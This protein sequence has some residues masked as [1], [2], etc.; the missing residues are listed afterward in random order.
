MPRPDPVQVLYLGSSGDVTA[1]RRS[2]EAHGGVTRSR[3]TPE[4]DVVVAD[5]GVSGDHPTAAAA[6]GLGIPVLTPTDAIDVLAGRMARP[7]GRHRA[8]EPVVQA[9]GGA[10]VVVVTIAVLV[11]VLTALGVVNAVL[12]P[13]TSTRPAVVE[14]DG[15]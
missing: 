15:R 1:L 6:R 13:G 9:A 2:M 14:Q 10:P 3:L 7:G 8:I 5:P 4:V 11:L 12:T